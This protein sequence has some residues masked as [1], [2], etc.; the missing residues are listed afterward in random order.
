[1]I[2]LDIG[3][4]GETLPGRELQNAPEIG[5]FHSSAAEAV[6]NYHDI[7]DGDLDFDLVSLFTDRG[8]VDTPETE[9]VYCSGLCPY[10]GWQMSKD[11]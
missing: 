6:L 10:C 7:E 5:P 11:D 9:S 4:G 3:R 8:G 1:M 2:G